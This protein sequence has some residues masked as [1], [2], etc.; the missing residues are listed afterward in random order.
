[1]VVNIALGPTIAISI[2]YAGKDLN[3]QNDNLQWI[4][5]AY[6]IS[7]VGIP[8]GSVS[9]SLAHLGHRH[10]SF[11]FAGGLQIFTAANLS[12]LLAI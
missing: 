12:G 5:S 11:F 1:M 6:S 9:F 7:S 2:P 8:C 10:A 4:V 3:I